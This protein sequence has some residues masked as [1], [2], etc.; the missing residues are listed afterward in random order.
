MEESG[1][2]IAEQVVADDT[3][4][5]R[6]RMA[7]KQLHFGEGEEMKLAA[8][9]EIKKVAAGET[10]G[11]RRMAALGVIPPMVAMVVEL[12]DEHRRRLVIETLEELAHG[13][14]K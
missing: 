8:V 1:G 10:Q 13:T 2:V 14:F 6:T 11:K 7:V 5:A 9:A 12:K 4:A 3:E